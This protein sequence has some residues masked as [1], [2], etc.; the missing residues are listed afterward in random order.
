MQNNFENASAQVHD[1]PS[2]D[3]VKPSPRS[4]YPELKPWL[5]T[6]LFWLGL[7]FV[8]VVFFLHNVS[9]YS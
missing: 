3:E 4:I 7:V 5:K 1:N 8:V 6:S 2:P 9:G